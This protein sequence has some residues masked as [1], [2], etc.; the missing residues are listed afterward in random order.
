MS[1]APFI[2]PIDGR[3]FA[4]VCAGISNHYGWPVGNVRLAT[5]LLMLGT[6]VGVV[7]Y[8]ALWIAI[9]GEWWKP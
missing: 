8:L 7:V 3:M 2:R 6:G 1:S 5:L 9:P 4:G